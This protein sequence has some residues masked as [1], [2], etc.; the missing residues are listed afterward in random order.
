VAG[1]NGHGNNISGPIKAESFQLA[2]Q[3][4]AFK[5][6]SALRNI[7]LPLCCKTF[8]VTFFVV[9][10]GIDHWTSGFRI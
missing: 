5:E 9:D 3:L 6:G 4:L 7:F 8:P 1:S 10:T 2:E